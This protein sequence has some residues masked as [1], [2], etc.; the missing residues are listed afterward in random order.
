MQKVSLK[1]AISLAVAA[2][3]A[4]VICSC[5][6]NSSASKAMKV[7]MVT[8]AGTIDDKSFNQGTWEGIVR[9]EKDLGVEIKYLKPVG[10]TEADY[11]KEISNLYDSGFKF[12]I[13]PGFKFETAVF[14]AQ[15]KYADA[16]FVIIDGNA[17]PADSWDPQNGPNTIGISFAEHESGFL[18]GVAAA[19]EL[20]EGRFGFIGGMEIPAVQKFNWGWQQGIQYANENLGTA[21]EL[22]QEDF[23]YQGTFSD[24]AAGQQI[25]ASMFDRGITCIHAAAGGVGVGVINEAK[26]RRQIGKTAWVVG[27]DVN[28]YNEG[29]L[30]DGKSVILTSAMKYL[31]RASFDMIKEELAGSFKGGRSLLL[32]AKEDAV[33][34]PT[35]NPNLSPA[36]QSKVNE[37]YNDI[38][39]GKIVVADSQGNLFR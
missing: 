15:S 7:G 32:T 19:L 5:G 34:I 12:I 20:K 35:E 9:A 37:I 1:K 25:A 10:T 4:L 11:V 22:F 3:A 29:L 26:A 18:A 6:G 13:C 39:A 8:D 33:G 17:H 16:K 31:D 30:P 38:K 28:Q 14:K 23:L 24:I 21:I 2:A 27:V 36:V